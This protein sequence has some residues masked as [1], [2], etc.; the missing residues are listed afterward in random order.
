MA[1]LLQTRVEDNLAENFK[2]AARLHGKT[3]GAYLHQIVEQAVVARTSR[4]N[5]HHGKTARRASNR[6]PYSL[7]AMLR[8]D[9]DE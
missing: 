4:P 8:T 6:L 2:R 3:P 7:V 9:E 5:G 1:V